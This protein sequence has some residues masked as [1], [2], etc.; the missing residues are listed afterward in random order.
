MPGANAPD[1]PMLPLVLKRDELARQIFDARRRT[2]SFLDS[3]KERANLATQ[4][5]VYQF[6]SHEL[7]KSNIVVW[8]P[9][10]LDAACYNVEQFNN[11][12]LPLYLVP[13]TPQWWPAEVFLKSRHMRE[14]WEE[15]LD[16]DV[17][18]YGA[19]LK[20]VLLTTTDTEHR[21]FHLRD[22]SGQT[23]SGLVLI[24]ILMYRSRCAMW[25]VGL[26]VGSI[27]RP[28]VNKF[29][30]CVLA[31]LSFMNSK[32]VQPKTFRLPVRF[33]GFRQ[34]YTP[35]INQILLRARRS[36]VVPGSLADTD[37][38]HREWAHCWTVRSHARRLR[39]P[40][41]SDG[42]QV[43][44]VAAHVK[45]PTDKPMLPPRDTIVKVCR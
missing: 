32:F 6:A 7:T 21:V 29:H 18:A 30:R 38:A 20:G 15:G 12:R 13:T 40:R 24:M 4:E 43:I 5:H 23:A 9:D 34:K 3:G 44:W 25:P 36:E 35:C 33:N 45:G 1:F 37:E 2:D 8:R 42:Q 27:I 11:T 16:T 19:V 17:R 39:Q 41:K 14:A 31:A 26:S 10:I 22:E 28:D